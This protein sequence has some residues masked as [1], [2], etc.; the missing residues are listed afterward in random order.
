MASD[1]QGVFLNVPYDTGYQPLFVT[2]VTSL[3][4]LG[5]KPR[6]VIEIREQG[7]GRL[8]RIFDLM[9]ACRVSIHDLSRVGRPARFNMPFELGLA[10]ALRL[11]GEL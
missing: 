10:C 1:P 4:C 9:R 5:Q 7:D 8:R 2:L 11:I 3:V 6:S